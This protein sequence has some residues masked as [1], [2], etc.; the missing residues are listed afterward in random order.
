LIKILAST[1]AIAAFASGFGGRPAVVTAEPFPLA[2]PIV[3]SDLDAFMQKVLARRDENWKKLQ[4]YILD[5]REQVE[6]RGPSNVPV[7]GERR[8]FSWYIRE[9]YFIK[10]PIKVNGVTVP[11]DDRRK[12]EDSFLKKVKERDKRGSKPPV[13]EGSPE[14]AEPEQAPKDLD[15]FL[16]QSRQPDFI[17]SAYFLRFK[18]EQGKY[19]FVG[20]EQFDGREVLKIEYYPARLFNHEQDK[21]ERKKNE[22]KTE[23]AK[24]KPDP[25]AQQKKDREDELDATIER[26]MNKVSLVTIWVEP[27]SFQIVKYTFDNVNFDFL[28]AAW[29]VRI[30]DLKASMTMSQPFPDVWLPRD[31]DM[32]FS[33]MVAIGAF[34]GHY[35]IDY[36]DYKQATTSGRIKSPAPE[37]R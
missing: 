22:P 35:R 32:F 28:P 26:L 15:S 18:F 17:D 30:N 27:K 6:I 31:V 37:P 11:E 20:R 29:L 33:A 10:S 2:A 16:K 12:A 7:W 14:R 23:P 25:K 1:A 34:D 21:E 36:H 3:Q 24:Q 8:D 19:A 5:E 9:G 4:Q 13:A